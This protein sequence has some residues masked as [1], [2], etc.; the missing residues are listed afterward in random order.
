MQQMYDVVIIGAGPAGACAAK[1][2]ADSGKTVLVLEKE[3]FPRFSIGE[4][5]LPQSMQFL[6]HCGML[7]AVNEY[8]FQLKN[9][10]A[11]LKNGQSSIFNFADKFTPGHADTFQVKRAEFDKLLADQ[12]SA[13][14]AEIRYQHQLTDYQ[15]KGNLVQLTAMALDTRTQYNIQAR[16]VLDASG[17]GRVLPKMLNLEVPSEFPSRQAVFTHVR[18]KCPAHFDRDKILI[19]VHPNTPDIWFWLIPFSDGTSSLGVVAGL[20]HF[21]ELND[22]SNEEILWHFVRQTPDLADLLEKA[23]PI[24]EVRNIVGYSANVSRLY[25]KHFALLGNAGEFLD[26]VFSSGVTIALK[27]ASLAVP[28]VC[29][30]LDGQEVDWDK[31]YSIRLRTG[32]STFWQF[33]SKWYNQDLQHIIFY[34]DPQPQVRKM[35]CSILAGYAWDEENPFVSDTERRLNVLAEICAS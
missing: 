14:G 28:L 13:G 1:M 12:A 24:A 15:D 2:L 5:L 10:A 32:I 8:G 30:Q 11:F 17:F 3:Q 26:P 27:S 35:I 22:M 31:E 25:G 19:T 16:F 20:E 21:A 33:V 34:R 9:G 23:E 29:R 18:D 7:N 4:S 6:Q